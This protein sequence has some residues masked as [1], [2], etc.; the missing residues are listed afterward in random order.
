[1]LISFSYNGKKPSICSIHFYIL[2][3]PDISFFKSFN[4]RINV[5][6]LI[7]LYLKYISYTLRDYRNN[8]L[9]GIMFSSSQGSPIYLTPPIPK[10]RH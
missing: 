2:T 10:Y 7:F 1:M 8:I 3:A 6:I 4:N 5:T 9:N